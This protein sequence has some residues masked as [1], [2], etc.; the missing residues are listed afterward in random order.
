[1]QIKD[2]K[3]ENSQP[4]ILF[5]DDD[6]ICLDVSVQMLQKLGYTVLEAK[7]GKEAIEVYKNNQ[8]KVDLVILDMKM[9]HNGGHTFEQLKKM[10]ADLKIILTSGYSED[11]GIRELVKQGCDGFLQKPF[12]AKILSQ[13]IMDALNN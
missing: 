5:A 12:G 7:D 11:Y 1:M 3:T 10:N 9:P 8:D 2:S 6:K 4:V 13:K